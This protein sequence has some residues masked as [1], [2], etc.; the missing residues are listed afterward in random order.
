MSPYETPDGVTFISDDWKA[1]LWTIPASLDFMRTAKAERKVVVIGS[2][3]DTPKSFYDRYQTVIRQALDVVD[4][5]IFVGEHAHS[6]LKARPNPEDER[7]M[8]FD[9]LYQLNSFLSDYLKAGDLVLLKGTK[10]LTISS[11]SYSRGL[12][13]LPAGGKNVENNVSAVIVDSCIV[14]L[15]RAIN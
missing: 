9:T 4:K 2:I 1:P 13:I 12:M 6:A 15:C 11:E 3:S 14:P 7:I 5:I 8:A 10:Y